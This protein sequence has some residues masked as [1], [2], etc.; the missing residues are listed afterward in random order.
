MTSALSSCNENIFAVARTLF[1]LSRQRKAIPHFLNSSLHAY[2]AQSRLFAQML[3]QGKPLRYAV[4][5][6][7]SRLL[8]RATGFPFSIQWLRS[9][10]YLVVEFVW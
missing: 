5:G 8:L 10:F 7:L 1:A 2:S 6:C 4:L 9:G 3:P